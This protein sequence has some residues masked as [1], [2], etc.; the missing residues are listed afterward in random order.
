MPMLP[1]WSLELHQRFGREL[2][3]GP[4]LFLSWENAAAPLRKKKLV[5]PKTRPFSAPTVLRG[6]QLSS[7]EEIL[8]PLEQSWDCQ[9]VKCM[10]GQMSRILGAVGQQICDRGHDDDG[11][12]EE[13]VTIKSCTIVIIS[14]R[15]RSIASI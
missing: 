7:P 2:P 9:Q 5:W 8:P 15:K 14:F 12:W 4:F 1:H 3:T 6:I 11:R 10:V 13:M